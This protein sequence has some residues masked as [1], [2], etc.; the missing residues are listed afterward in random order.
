M[1]R[2]ATICA[3]GG[4]KGVPGKNL[5]PVAGKPLLDWTVELAM[6]SGLFDAVVV[7]SDDQAILDR[8]ALVGA[9]HCVLRPQSLAA[10]SS[11]KLGAIEHAVRAGEERHGAQAR[12]IV[13]LDVTSPLRTVADV[14]GALALLEAGAGNVIT[15]CVA[16]R[17]PFFN[18]V[19]RHPDGAV[20]PVATPPSPIVRRQDA[21]QCFDMNASI[22]VWWR[23][24]FLDHPYVFDESTELYE[25]PTERSFDIDDAFDLRIV[26]WLLEETT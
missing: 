12:I 21:P 11:S 4:S 25:M 26:E 10:D 2:L 24:R 7:D 17:S 22:Y 8:A 23:D 6:S 14:E 15:G 16:R 1:N 19:M 13:D 3:R 5:R 20:A 9:D 18:L